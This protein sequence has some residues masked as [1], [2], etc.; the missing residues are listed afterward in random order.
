MHEGR[1]IHTFNSTLW[2]WQYDTPSGSNIYRNGKTKCP[3]YR[4]LLGYHKAD[5]EAQCER[6]VGSGPPAHR[7]QIRLIFYAKT[8]VIFRLIQPLRP[9]HS[10]RSRLDISR[11]LLDVVHKKCLESSKELLQDKTVCMNSDGWSNV[12]NEPVI[13]ATVTTAESELVLVDTADTSGHAHTADY[14]VQEAVDTIQTC[15]K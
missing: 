6:V 2:Q 5:V 1:F 12:L 13:C 4:T 10:P 9:G 11:K 8:R 7:K 3:Q 14:L 15:D